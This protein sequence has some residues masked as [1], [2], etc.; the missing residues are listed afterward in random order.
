[1]VIVI[2]EIVGAADTITLC[3]GVADDQTQNNYGES[4]C[5][6]FGVSDACP[7]QE[8]QNVITN[9]EYGPVCG[10]WIEVDHANIMF[11][12]AL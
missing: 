3:E 8:Q 5:A 2:R 6:H 7:E 11:L 12:G 10:G 9:D 4:E 1:L